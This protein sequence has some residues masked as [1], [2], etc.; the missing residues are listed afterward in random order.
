VLVDFYVFVT[1]DN[2]LLNQ[3]KVTNLQIA[4]IV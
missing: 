1:I 2:N 3:Q 4:P